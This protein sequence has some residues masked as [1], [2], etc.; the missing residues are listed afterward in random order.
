MKALILNSG[1]GSRMGDLTKTQPKC[2]TEISQ[3]E[4]ILSRQLSLLAETGVSDVVITTGF[5]HDQMKKYCKDLGLDI[6]FTFVRNNDF[7]T[8]NYIYSIYLARKLLND[9]LI[10]MHGD[11]VFDK[12]VLAD[13]L[14]SE[15]SCMTVSSTLDLPEKDFKAVITDGKISAIGIDFFDNA[16]AAQPLYKLFRKDWE[17]WLDSI[18]DFC[19]SNNTKVYAENAFNEVSNKCNVFPLDVK[20]SLCNE[21][22]TLEDLGNIKQKLQS[23]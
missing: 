10:L 22:D 17:V 6:N 1:T 15:K 23:I 5:F 2:M 4:T 3:G 18:C 7:S 11:L 21:I 14:K 12:N 16:M 8:T 13:V 9:D 19:E 20:N